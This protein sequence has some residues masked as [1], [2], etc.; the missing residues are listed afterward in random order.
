MEYLLS[1]LWQSLELVFLHL[2]WSAFFSRKVSAPRYVCWFSILLIISLCYTHLLANSALELIIALSIHLLSAKVLYHGKT[3][4]HFISIAFAMIMASMIDVAVLYGT[5]SFLRISL[6][7]FTWRILSYSVVVTLGKLISILVAWIL[8]Q[9]RNVQDLAQTQYKWTLL[10]LLFPAVSYIMLLIL[11]D[12]YADQNDMSMV[13]FLFTCILVVANL[14]S[15][16]LINMLV[17]SERTSREAALMKQQ[18]AI[19]TES[20]MA[21][22]RNY[23]TQRKTVHEFQHHLQTIHDLLTSSETAIVQKYVSSLQDT[24]TTRILAVNSRHPI[25]DAILNHKYQI[26]T[27]KQI[28][29]QIQVND[30]SSVD[31]D[32]GALV[33]L[34]SNLLDNA[35]EACIRI[36]SNPIIDCRILHDEGLLFI[37]ISNTSL[38]VSSV[39]NS[40]PTSKSPKQD[41]GYGLM[42]ICHILEQYNA[43]Y[44]FTFEDGYFH[45]VAELPLTKY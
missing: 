24:Q 20:I 23:R 39:N 25:I 9:H 34:L 5:C 13:A 43:E 17:S 37:S 33:V 31:F 29:V 12:S 28:D 10:S 45:F 18:M 35:I 42:I 3:W 8:K 27:E 36:E 11:F 19:Q 44:T 26:A 15:L 32:I 1:I 38:P 21:L 4:Q 16:Y 40:I 6:A 41:H 7:D 30:L 22:E 14:A 2:F